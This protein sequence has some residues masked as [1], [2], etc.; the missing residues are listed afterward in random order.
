M[1]NGIPENF[2]KKMWIYWILWLK[3]MKLMKMYEVINSRCWRETGGN[4][5][6]SSMKI[7]FGVEALTWPVQ[8]RFESASAKR[9]ELYYVEAQMQATF[10]MQDTWR[11]SNAAKHAK[12]V[13]DR[14]C[15]K[16]MV[17]FGRRIWQRTRV[18]VSLNFY[19][20][21]CVWFEMAGRACRLW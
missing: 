11:L 13:C 20:V 3:P 9:N 10:Q 15:R 17:V 5:L 8:E 14:K 19:F 16:E 18:C 2:L 6:R 7:Y 12:H 4:G 21:V 1:V